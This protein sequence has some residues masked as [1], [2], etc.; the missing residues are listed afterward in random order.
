[1]FDLPPILLVIGALSVVDSVHV[2]FFYISD[3]LPRFIREPDSVTARPHGK[4]VL[5]C[6]V[7]PSDARIRWIYNGDFISTNENQGVI[8]TK[9]ILHIKSFKHTRSHKPH[10]GTY[11]CVATTPLG[12][13]VSRP[14]E[15]RRANIK[16]F[17]SEEKPS[18][19]VNT[20]EGNVA[21]I[22]CHPP[23]GLPEPLVS[24]QINGSR[25]DA[26]ASN[27]HEILPS[28]SLQISEVRQADQGTYRCRAENILTDK[29]RESHQLVTLKVHAPVDNQPPKVV[30][31][32]QQHVSVIRGQDVTLECVV[33]GSP[34]PVVTWER[35]A[36]ILPDGRFEQK[37]GNLILKDVQVQDSGTYVC[38]ADNLQ[39]AP[40]S[41]HTILEVLEPPSIKRAPRS[42][43]VSQG[44]SVTFRCE[45]EARTGARISWFHN[46]KPL[47][48]DSLIS[49]DATTMTIRDVTM[50]EAGLYQ[51][52]AESKIGHAF[53]IARLKVKKWGYKDPTTKPQSI[54][55]DENPIFSAVSKPIITMGPSNLTSVQGQTITL[56]CIADAAS[57]VSWL[58]DGTPLDYA[59]NERHDVSPTGSLQIFNG[60]LTDAGE[61]I[62]LASNRM[63]FT[64][65]SAYLIVLPGVV[66]TGPSQIPPTKDQFQDI[67]EKL[68]VT[69]TTTPEPPTTSTT[70]T[71]S[72][73]TTL[74][75]ST[76]TSSPPLPVSEN[77][78]SIIPE[79]VENVKAYNEKQDVVT[80]Q[81]P[82]VEAEDKEDFESEDKVE[83]VDD[84]SETNDKED[85]EL[86]EDVQPP[87]VDEVTGRHHVTDMNKEVTD[88]ATTTESINHA[89][90]DKN[91]TVDEAAGP[92]GADENV[93]DV[94]ELIEESL[95]P[96]A[97]KNASTN[98][99]FEADYKAPATKEQSESDDNK[100]V[101][102]YFDER[103]R[104]EGV[105][106][107]DP[108][109]PDN[110][111]DNK[112]KNVDDYEDAD[113]E[114]G[115]D[116]GNDN[117]ET[118]NDGNN[119][120]V[121][122]RVKE[123][124][125]IL[126]DHW[127]EEDYNDETDASLNNEVVRGDEVDD[128]DDDDWGSL[129]G[130]YD[131]S[132]PT[133]S[134]MAKFGENA[135][136]GN[137]GGAGRRRNK[138]KKNKKRKNKKNRNRGRPS[139][140]H[141]DEEPTAADV[142]N[143]SSIVPV[144]M[145]PPSR[146]EVSKLSD[147]SVML[148]WDVPLNDGLPIAF[149]RVQYRTI[150]KNRKKKKRATWH[151]IDEDIAD[152]HRK[153]E[154]KG[155]KPGDTYRFRIVAVYS[156]NDNKDG[157]KS[158]K[159]MLEAVP[160]HRPKR[161]VAGPVIVEVNPL[162]GG[163]IALRW[164]HLMI[165]TM[166]IEGFVIFYRPFDS[167]ED[168]I[169]R[170]IFGG[171]HVRH[172]LSQLLPD[173][174]YQIKMKCFNSAGASDFSNTVVKRTL[175]VDGKPKTGL[176]PVVD[177]KHDHTS[178]HD[179]AHNHHS[180]TF[181]INRHGHGHISKD[182]NIFDIVN[183]VKN[184]KTKDTDDDFVERKLSTQSSSTLLYMVLGIVLGV[185]MLLLVIFMVMC[186]WKQRQQRRMMALDA[187]FRSKFQDSSQRIHSDSI[188]KKYM[189]GGFALNALNGD[190]NPIGSPGHYANGSICNGYLGGSTLGSKVNI[191][192][193]PMTQYD[194]HSFMNENG[195]FQ[196][197][198]DLAHSLQ[199][200]LNGG[201]RED[202]G[203]IY[204]SLDRRHQY[205]H[206]S[207][208]GNSS[209]E[210]INRLEYNNTFNS[211]LNQRIRGST[212]KPEPPD[213]SKIPN[214]SNERLDRPGDLP[215]YR[216]HD[217]IP[218][219]HEQYANQRPNNFLSGS[220]DHFSNDLDSPH[221]RHKRRKKRHGSRDRT[222]MK[223]QSTNTDGSNEGTLEN[224]NPFPDHMSLSDH[225]SL[226][227][228]SLDALRNENPYM[229]HRRSPVVCMPDIPQVHDYSDYN[230]TP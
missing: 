30:L 37:Y 72:T 122:N 10:A 104:P 45:P 204:N 212:F 192:V 163:A 127:G 147:T 229:Q 112:E 223:D 51:C 36:A 129:D 158:D 152:S 43:V 61:Y 194:T 130:D 100:F 220:H 91:E 200:I 42:Q 18:L 125:R 77:E 32:P 210:D 227:Y 168:Y 215:V 3:D 138:K 186:G 76:T 176:F 153:Y 38:R 1:M 166:A 20:T 74:K 49:I 211:Q 17:D 84:G 35:V 225:H 101:K 96:V 34:V 110:Y 68:P 90:S 144:K 137:R 196:S 87:K 47:Y 117:G 205:E 66:N 31:A 228:R 53:A 206:H 148:Q 134:S 188:R 121:N 54:A 226:T 95:L 131:L 141:V 108:V 99:D 209:A 73:T 9:G 182:I 59:L 149:F 160:A 92:S 107:P 88:V 221:L 48:R 40:T 157:A 177:S 7:H 139:I 69:T 86:V 159:F 56:L 106:E 55:P 208:V 133:S 11:H 62:C 193:N 183:K 154:V 98:F 195:Y 71:I 172:V 124:D 201:R 33:T 175:P 167:G 109:V 22:P 116:K 187:N 199:E 213:P 50:D 113:Y 219:S 21:L 230:L 14:V 151:T 75:P 5:H 16:K 173:T 27:R 85:N 29:V 170:T 67:D 81:P 115:N 162:P 217:Q 24:F 161:P 57:K 120:S 82:V 89:A 93:D 28:G 174:E 178:H 150:H 44:D 180:N 189:N 80:A 41:R 15:V 114:Y 25:F 52:F 207:I 155:L 136:G 78:D 179:H 171:Q 60:Q 64:T 70:T 190:I 197:N 58:K 140:I 102:E 79:E 156:N 185:M 202:L 111:E 214:R 118:F 123:D 191:N 128:I 97:E 39:G 126:P 222:P 216:S 105:E 135:G 13:I 94:K 143:P 145:V 142:E 23:Y 6:K 224:N 164:K 119:E 2:Y 63:G 12:S 103:G 169:R 146:P 46:A 26:S 4:V 165:D 198:G 8:I 132:D 19:I 203:G 181:G 65:A 83:D 184:N 218:R